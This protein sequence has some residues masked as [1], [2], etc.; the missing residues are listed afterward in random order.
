MWHAKLAVCVVYDIFDFS[1][2]RLLFPIPFFG[3]IVGC[4]ICCLLFG[5]AGVAYGLEAIDITEQ[6]DGFI[7]AATIIAIANRPAETA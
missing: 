4:G 7:P 3:E 2:G 5:K 6:L 1:V